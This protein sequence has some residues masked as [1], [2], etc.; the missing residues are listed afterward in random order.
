MAFGALRRASALAVSALTVLAATAV[1]A[2]VNVEAAPPPTTGGSRCPSSSALNNFV[3]ATNVGAS[4]STNGNE[5]TYTFESFLDENPVGGVPGLIKY[6]VYPPTQPTGVTATAAGANGAA[7]LAAAGRQGFS[8][9]RPGG[10]SSNIP[11]D[12]TDTEVGTATWSGTPPTE[13]QILL[14]INDPAVCADLYGDDPGTCFVK[15]GQPPQA[16]TGRGTQA[17]NVVYTSMPTD[18]L[19][20]PTMP[21]FAFEANQASEF[22]DGV[23]LSTT[24]T[25]STLRV[26]FGSYGCSVSGHWNTGDCVTTPGATFTHPIT[27]NIYAVGAGGQ[28]GTLLATATQTFTIAYRP[29]ADPACTGADAGGWFNG[30]INGCESKIRQLLT[31]TMPA[32]QLPNQVIWTVAFNTTHYGANPIGE[33]TVCFASAPGCGYDSLNVATMTYPGSPYVGTD[34]DAN[35]AYVDSTWAGAYCDGGAGG[36][37]SLRLDTAATDCWDGF[38]PLGEI[39]IQ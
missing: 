28:P 30:D 37:G 21:T 6:C 15:P 20:C 11:L 22:G 1:V 14:H 10:N 7:W 33:N 9:M 27:A 36:L 32:V 35:G 38:R 26:M 5:V 31:F 34:L 13:Q 8:F 23:G 24:G 4:F 39:S 3:T 2:A 25:L 18:V 12:G 19:N 17:P 29:S 16:C